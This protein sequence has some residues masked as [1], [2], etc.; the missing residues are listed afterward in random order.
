MQLKSKKTYNLNIAVISWLVLIPVLLL[1]IFIFI[2]VLF[3]KEA[4]VQTVDAVIVLGGGSGERLKT[5]LDIINAGFS[6][7]LVLNKGVNWTSSAGREVS[8]ICKAGLINSQK[9]LICMVAHPDSTKGE[10]MTF[11]A[12]AS[13]RGWNRIGVVTNSYH[14]TRSRIWFER[15]FAGEVDMIVAPYRTN[16]YQFFREGAA[17]FQTMLLDRVCSS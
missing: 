8:E 15:C 5:G 14:S 3:P 2:G 11:S 6:N 17:L 16:A 1:I 7:T 9:E 12:L 4:K 13:A 10:A